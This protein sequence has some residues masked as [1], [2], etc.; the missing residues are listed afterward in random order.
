MTDAAWDTRGMGDNRPPV[1]EILAERN[2]ELRPLLEAEGVDLT[3]RRDVLLEATANAPT[4]ITTEEECHKVEDLIKMILSCAKDSEARRKSDKAPTREAGAIVDGFYKGIADQPFKNSPLATA[5][6]TLRA[7][8]NVY[9]QQKAEAERRVREEIERKAREEAEKAAR[10]AA[11]LEQVARDEKG[12]EAAILAEAAAK[13]AAADSELAQ[14]E[15]AANAAEL[16]RTRSDYGAV[17]SLRTFWDHTPEDSACAD[18][19]DRDKVDKD[20]IW[21]FIPM[22]ALDKAVKGYVKA[23]GREC[24]GVRIFK[25]TSAVV[26]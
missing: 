1:R 11:R 12:L 21:P 5:D 26:R 25:D 15:A 14:K 6:K 20:L 17:A 13:I 8:L 2:K 19:V 23:G 7:P 3:E 24:R 10:E 9:L 4:V 22:D 16:S 18:P